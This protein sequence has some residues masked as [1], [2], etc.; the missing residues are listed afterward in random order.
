[1]HL[2]PPPSSFSF[3]FLTLLWGDNGRGPLVLDCFPPLNEFPLLKKSFGEQSLISRLFFN[4]FFS[5]QF[6]AHLT[7]EE[8]HT[9]T[10]KTTTKA[11]ISC[12][13]TKYAMPRLRPGITVVKLKIL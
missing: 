4:E 12:R 11:T 6:P 2:S 5:P 1:V 10:T 9:F 7:R 13:P 3:H 8:E